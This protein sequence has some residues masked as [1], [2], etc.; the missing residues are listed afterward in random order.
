MTT[1]APGG[2]ATDRDGTIDPAQGIRHFTAGT[3]GE[4]PRHP[5]RPAACILKLTL[6][7]NGSRWQ[8]LSQAACLLSRALSGQRQPRREGGELGIWD[9]RRHQL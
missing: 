1:S 6:S 2:P 9:R 3:G 8:F 4:R 7:R 5:R